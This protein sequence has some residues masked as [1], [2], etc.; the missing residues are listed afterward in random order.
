MLLLNNKNCLHIGHCF[1]SINSSD[2]EISIL[3]FFYK[4]LVN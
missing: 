4:Y 3:F 1:I 2:S